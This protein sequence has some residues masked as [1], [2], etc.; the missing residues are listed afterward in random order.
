M[1]R[2]PGFDGK[3]E[4]KIEDG[5]VTEFRI[6]TDKVTDIAPIRVFKALRVLECRGTANDRAQR[7]TGG[8][9]SAGGNEPGG[10]DAS[11]LS[12]TKVT[13][14]G[15]AYFKDCKNLTDL[16]L[17]HEGE[18]R[19][20]GPLQGLQEPD[21][22]RP[23]RHAGERR[24]PGPLQGLQEPDVPHS[25]PNE[26][27]RRGP[28]HFKG[29]PLSV[30]WIDNT[31]ITD[32]TPLQG[33]PLEDI[34]LTP[35]NITRG[36][37]ILRDMKSLKTIGISGTKPGRRRSSGSAT[38]RGSSRSSVAAVA[39][40]CPCSPWKQ[41]GLGPGWTEAAGSVPHRPGWRTQTNPRLQSCI[42]TRWERSR[43]HSVSSTNGRKRMSAARR[44]A[45][46]LHVQLTMLDA[47]VATNQAL[48]PSII[49]TNEHTVRC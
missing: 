19:G 31:G 18:R 44:T 22:P 13:D 6:V 14:A 3:V 27:E 47:S 40:G 37:D 20:P 26:G 2:N 8:P 24:G 17:T 46:P 10:P 5:V 41:F 49:C 21:D 33:M 25:G 42:S 1:R 4:H 12:N 39:D 43:K 34:R 32:L 15:M 38:T 35:K 36:L 11:R 7:A 28:G 45:T 29:M 23:G 9:D 16:D 30:L 48:S